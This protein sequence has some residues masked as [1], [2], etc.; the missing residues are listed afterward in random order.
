[1]SPRRIRMLAV[2]AGAV[3]A[4]IVLTRLLSTPGAILFQGIIFGL[5]NGLVAAG[6]VLVYRSSRIIN[7]SQAAMGAL[8]ATF[9]FNFVRVSGWPYLV[10]F[11]A[12]IIVSVL[13]GLAVELLIIRRFFAAPR[14]A[15]TVL[16]IALA[17]LLAELGGVVLSLPIF[18]EE[19]ASATQVEL[20]AALKLPFRHF[21]FHI[22]NPPLAID[23]G[24]AH[25][26]AIVVTIGALVGLGAF[27]RYSRAGVAVRASAENAERAELL[28]ISVKAL[29]TLVWGIA[30]FLSGLGVILTGTVS[31]GADVGGVAPITLVP[32]L[33][34]AVLGMMRSV[35]LAVFAAVA[36]SVVRESFGWSFQ[37]QGALI[38]VGL[39]V[40]V[41]ASLLIQRKRLQRSEVADTSSWT[42]TEEIRPTPKELSGVGGIR[43]W[44]SIFIGVGSAL[45]LL[46]PWLTPT[47]ATNFGGFIAIVGIVIASLVV[48]TGWAGQVS[49]GQFAF[50][51]VGA[52]TGGAMTAQWHIPFL[53]AVLLAS[54]ITAFVAVLVGIPA[55]RI[56]G[57]FLAVATFSLAFAVEAALF[58]KEYFGWLLPDRVQRPTFLFLDFEDERSMYYLCV[59]AFAL[60]LLLVSTLRRYRTG[61]ALIGVRDNETNM[62]SFAIK[63]VR[64]RLGAFALSGFL[65]GFAGALL[66]HH[67]RAVTVA[68]F[69]AERSLTIFLIAVVGGITSVTGAI[70][71]TAYFALRDS[72]SGELKFLAGAAGTVFI[73]YV[74][75]TGLGGMVYAFRDA[76]FRIVAQRRQIVVPSLMA[77]YDP[78]A[79]EKRL[80]PITTPQDGSR[81]AQL[82]TLKKYAPVSDLYRNRGRLLAAALGPKT[83]RSEEASALGAASEALGVEEP[84]GAVDEPSSEGA[85]T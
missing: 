30:G 53:L 60:S 50:V 1:M 68:S 75:P 34:A 49:L 7:F 62:Q 78:A 46:Y 39:F 45:V 43:A 18:P 21:E 85:G 24:F 22:G 79:L 13:V 84:M 42:A 72:L 81:L 66:A 6:L 77:D 27:F 14:L 20:T 37:G 36:I 31:R 71:G 57:L 9:T 12:G 4:I 59:G 35:P 40:L 32:A 5:L 56:R 41:L 2:P 8:G 17:G 51:A 61:R 26:F 16:T 44:R 47:G 25:I 73:L 74:Y 3:V 76:I 69:G 29:S 80:I 54:I 82:L 64:T 58:K 11:A 19:A 10:A 83:T 33:A 15:V 55:L 48:L 65:C 38:D 23:F 28:G 70:L 63:V 52:V 67:Q